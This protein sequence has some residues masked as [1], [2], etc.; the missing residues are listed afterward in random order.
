MTNTM[1]KI[2]DMIPDYV[3]EDT[4]ATVLG[5][6][7]LFVSTEYDPDGENPLEDWDGMGMIRSFSSRHHNSVRSQEEAE[8]LLADPDAVVLSYF[9]HG[10]CQW[11][12]RGSMGS[13]PDFQWDG[14][15]T[16]GV[17]LPDEEARNHIKIT[18]AKAYGVEI[19]VE[20][21]SRW[22]AQ[23]EDCLPWVLRVGESRFDNWATAAQFALEL[24]AR[25]AGAERVQKALYAAAEET[26]AGACETFTDWCNGEVYYYSVELYELR[27]NEGDVYDRPDDYRYDVAIFEDSCGGFFGWK[28]F[29]GEVTEV[30]KAALGSVGL[31]AE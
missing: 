8:E 24:A 10:R 12:V 7:I 22:A 3:G 26:A 13:M 16:A 21:L 20:Q 14:V 6:Y 28:Y 30:V 5:D 9:E 19:H 2:A 11:G 29:L 25:E 4:K 27:K 1:P 18:A 17:W 23:A 31:T 15:S